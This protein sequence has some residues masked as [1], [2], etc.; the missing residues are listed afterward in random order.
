MPKSSLIVSITC[1]AGLSPKTPTPSQ[2]PLQSPPPA[3]TNRNERQKGL[4]ARLRFSQ[5][6]DRLLRGE[7]VGSR[8]WSV[9]YF[10]KAESAYVAL[11][12]FKV[13]PHRGMAVGC[14]KK[15]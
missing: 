7:F 10:K 4:L 13:L 12:Y 8:L 5:I 3:N 14:R 1:A 6:L 11:G 2:R 9:G 15:T